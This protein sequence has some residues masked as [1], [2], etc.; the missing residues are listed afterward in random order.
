MKSTFKIKNWQLLRARG[1]EGRV[2]LPKGDFVAVGARAFAGKHNPYVE[3]VVIPDGV[4][5]IKAQAFADCKNLVYIS[6]SKYNPIY[7]DVDGVLFT[8]DGE[9]LLHYPAMHT[10][11]SLYLSREVIEIA[12]MAFYQCAYLSSIRYEGSAEEWHLIDIGSKNY[13]LTAASIIFFARVG[14]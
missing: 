11:S 14:A 1:V 6:V 5:G 10:G 2:T 7:C 8:A 3:S 13:S 9:R 12:D 4:S